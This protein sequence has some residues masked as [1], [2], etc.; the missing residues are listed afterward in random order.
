MVDASRVGA[1]CPAS[2]G[3]AGWLNNAT[4]LEDDLMP[5]LAATMR[6][7]RRLPMP[8]AVTDDDLRAVRVP[9]LALFGERSQLYDAKQAA[10]R[11]QAL[12]PAVRTEIVPGA[13]H[14]LP[15]HSPHLI[16]D[17]IIDF[18]DTRDRPG[19]ASGTIPAS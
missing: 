16:L 11:M 15:M 5:L 17:R 6:F 12:L 18:L 8:A 14:D 2:W 13:S 1:T 7:R 10:S 4:L 3:A 9:T 19:S